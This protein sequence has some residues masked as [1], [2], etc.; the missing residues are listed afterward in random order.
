V[1]YHCMVDA[2]AKTMCMTPQELVDDLPHDGRSVFP[3]TQIERSHHIQ[4][5]IDV[6]SYKGVW[7]CPIELVPQSFDPDTRK[8]FQLFFGD[9]TVSSNF[10]RFK[11]YLKESEGVIIGM[12]N[13]IGHAVF[14]YNGVCH[15]DHG[16]WRLWSDGNNFL[17]SIFW[18]RLPLWKPVLNY[19]G[20]YEISDH[21]TIR[22]LDRIVSHKTSH[23]NN[24]QDGSCSI[25][26]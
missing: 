5:I 22:S 19:E 23:Q 9:G 2:F 13:N 3:G 17:P 4:E 25:V 14:C 6:A 18:K 7:F 20:L 21:G 12:R 16:E 10:D 26:K 15:D 11:R 24:H 1:S 8:N